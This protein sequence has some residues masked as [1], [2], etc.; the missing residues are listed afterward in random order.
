MATAERVGIGWVLWVAGWALLTGCGAF[1]VPAYFLLGP[2]T[3]SVVLG[4]VITL[5]A[6]LAWLAS[7]AA[8]AWNAEGEARGSAAPVHR[9]RLP[10]PAAVTAKSS[11]PAQR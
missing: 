4:G 1:V 3:G 8:G 5:S 11:R 2:T 9:R 10:R 7:S 6:G